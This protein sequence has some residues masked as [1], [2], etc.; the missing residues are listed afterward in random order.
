MK[1]C[2][3][4]WTVKPFKSESN[5]LSAEI[6]RKVRLIVNSMEA[7]Y[8]RGSNPNAKSGRNGSQPGSTKIAVT[9]A[10]KV[11]VKQEPL[12]QFRIGMR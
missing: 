3:D 10:K 9:I 1:G 7:L 8:F 4:R 2:A 11:R 12:V 5:P 6:A